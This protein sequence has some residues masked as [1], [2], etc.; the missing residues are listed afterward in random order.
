MASQGESLFLARVCDQMD[1][2]LESSHLKALPVS[3]DSMHLLPSWKCIAKDGGKIF[4][5][6]DYGLDCFV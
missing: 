6:I 1:L 3:A 5:L 2:C 4:S